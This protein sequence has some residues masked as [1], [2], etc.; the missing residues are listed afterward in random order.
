M[1]GLSRKT[2]YA[3]AA[4]AHLAHA[5]QPDAQPL[6][7]RALAAAE[8]MPHAM[9]G[10]LLK[11]LQRAGLVNSRRGVE[12]G[13]LLADPPRQITIGRLV[14]AI[15]GPHAVKLAACC[16]QPDAADPC[17]LLPK[18]P[19]SHALQSVNDRLEAFLEQLTLADL[20]PSRHDSNGRDA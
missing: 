2:D 5:R 6:S 8:Q 7:A 10:G 19:I 9:V 13:Y 14:R 4:L 16:S 1:F 12:G 15:E 3:V 18:C 17:Q 11:K 20:M